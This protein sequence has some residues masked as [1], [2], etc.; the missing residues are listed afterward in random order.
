MYP[1]F[2]SML[3]QYG[4]CDKEATVFDHGHWCEEHYERA[5]NFFRQV[6]SE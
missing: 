4:Q 2:S 3:C 5:M 1:T 6:R